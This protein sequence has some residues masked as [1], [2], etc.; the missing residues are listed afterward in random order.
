MRVPP[1]A[2]TAYELNIGPIYAGGR[3]TPELAPHAQCPTN[4]ARSVCNCRRFMSAPETR[5]RPHLAETRAPG[6]AACPG[7][8][9]LLR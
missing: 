4:D 2:V 8:A 1:G 3:R 9:A 6:G 5:G 7:P